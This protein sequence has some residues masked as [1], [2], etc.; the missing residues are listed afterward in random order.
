VELDRE[1][2]ERKSPSLDPILTVE[3]TIAVLSNKRTL[4]QFS[5]MNIGR[6]Q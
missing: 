6:D 1:S 4:V 2:I 5:A 3:K